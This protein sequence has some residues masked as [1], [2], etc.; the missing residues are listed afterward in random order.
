MKKTLK[1]I[2]IALIICVLLCGCSKKEKIVIYTS[3]EE[4]RIQELKTKAKEEFKDVE[5][6]VQSIS[7]GNMAAKLTTEGKNIEA[8]IILDL[9]TAYASDLENNFADIS[10]MK[11]VDTSIYLD[12]VNK[13]DKYLTWVKYSINL[14][15][16]NDYLK[17]HK[18]E[19]PKTY[20]DLLKKEYKGLIAMPDPKTSGTGYAF[21][22]NVVN[23]MGEKKAIEYFTKLKGNLRE[24]TASGS[25]PSNLLKQGEIAIAMGM[26]SQGVTA[27]NEGYNFSIVQLET[28][29]LYNTTSL[30]IVDG[31]QDKAKVQEV[32]NW[33]IND[34]GV[35]DKANHMPDVILKDQKSNIKN[36]PT[37]L[38]DANMKDIDNNKRKT[39]L[40]EMWSEVK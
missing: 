8:D 13:S 20:E 36:Y 34:Y 17:K 24:F 1:R 38:K 27:I 23:E 12:G 19:V 22:L 11:D 40:I 5:V 25:G 9:E 28:G 21:Y 29:S 7:T 18:L 15:V 3:M 32:F 10:K 39:E 33:I 26:T 16:D 4:N 30:A 14:I 2:L 6:V 37:N 31:K 35:Y